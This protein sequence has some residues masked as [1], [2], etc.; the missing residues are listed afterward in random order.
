MIQ[1]KI[2]SYGDNLS[3]AFYIRRKVFCEELGIPEKEEFDEL[4]NEA[5]HVIVYDNTNSEEAIATGRISY[6]EGSCIISKVSVLKKHRG[7][8]YGDFTV[9]MLINRAFVAGI[10][11]VMLTATEKDVE[12][13]KKIGFSV[14]GINNK[15]RYLYNMVISE[16]QVSKACN[17]CKK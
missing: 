7:K 5:M 3:E 16:N 13:F 17:H 8:K 12:F 15:N 9:K 2:L 10:N 6:H 4:D 11:E 14:T 1:G